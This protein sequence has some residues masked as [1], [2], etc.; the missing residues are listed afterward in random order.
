MIFLFIFVVVNSITLLALGVLL[1]RNIWVLGSNVTTIEGWEIERHRTLVRRARAHGGY[2]DGPDGI[3]LKITKQ[4]FPYD[5]GVYQ[6]VKQAMGS[7]FLLWLWPFTSTPSDTSGL[8]FETNGF[9]D[10]GKAWPPPDP[11]RIPRRQFKLNEQ[12]PFTHGAGSSGLDVQAFR[13]RQQ[14]DTL[15]FIDGHVAVT[16][17]VPFHQAREDGSKDAVDVRRDVVN[18]RRHS[19][20]GSDWRDSEGDR[21]EDFGVDEEAEG[22]GEE[23]LPLAELLKQK[24]AVQELESRLPSSDPDMMHIIALCRLT[25]FKNGLAGSHGV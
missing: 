4:E 11:D 5:I 9:E 25:I 1:L 24:K 17:R 19:N 22:Y 23:D 12:D 7:T 13:E 10:P 16:H 8:D 15:R 2:L 3:R 21:L 18:S 20:S 6:N 14:K